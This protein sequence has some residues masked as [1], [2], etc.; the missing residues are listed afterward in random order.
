MHSRRSFLA[1]SAVAVVA[2]SVA[3]RWAHARQQK[4]PP[5]TPVLTDIRRNVGFF[6][7]RDGTV[8]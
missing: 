6:T 8:G 2:G 7:G 5:V 4:T 1:G 3:P